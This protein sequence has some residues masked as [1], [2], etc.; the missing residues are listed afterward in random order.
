MA[1]LLNLAVTPWAWNC[2]WVEKAV[3]TLVKLAPPVRVWS[4][5]ERYDKPRRDVLLMFH[6]PPRL[7]PV[8]L[9]LAW[10]EK[11]PSCP[12][13]VRPK[14]VQVAGLTWP[15]QMAPKSTSLVS[16]TVIVE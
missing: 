1:G 6:R 13:G 14:A 9:P 4:M 16:F 15:K 8:P 12:C 2:A 3:G 7:K 5:A 11:K 10:A